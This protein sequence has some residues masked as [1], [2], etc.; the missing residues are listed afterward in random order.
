MYLSRLILNPRNRRVQ[1]EIAD[2]YQL[3]RSLMTAFPDDLGDDDERV[4]FR[5]EESHRGR[6]LA[7]LLQS[8]TMPDWSWLAEPGA[9]GYLL[10]VSEP[11]PAVKQFELDLTRGQ[12]LAF[13]L[14]AN[15]TAHRRCSDGVRRRVGLHDEEDQ[16]DWLARKG[17][18]GGFAL[19]AVRSSG[20]NTVSGCVYRN[21]T[22]HE[23]TLFSVQFDGLLEVRDPDR[24]EEAVREGVGS[25]KAF[26]FGLLSLGP[27]RT[28]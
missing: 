14:R 6:D 4:L 28:G 3:H 26:G 9:R 22:S 20:Q 16:M 7:L 18:R 25:A 5:V 15:P 2:R 19:L 21:G 27:P 11:N 17:E 12:R 10:P 1:K 24:V 8:W 13:R 23:L